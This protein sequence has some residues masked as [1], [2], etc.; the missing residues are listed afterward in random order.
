MGNRKG[1]IVYRYEILKNK[2]KF[3]KSDM[4]NMG[5]VPSACS[6]KQGSRNMFAVWNMGMAL[7]WCSEKE[8]K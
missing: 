1:H 2:K 8:N 5:S 3:L 6:N 7:G 4:Q